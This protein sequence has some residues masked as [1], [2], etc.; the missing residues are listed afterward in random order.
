L[1]AWE[2]FIRA[3]FLYSQHSEEGSR[4]A[5]SL[6]D[7]A[8]ELDTEYGQAYG[9]KAFTLLWRAF[10]SWEDMGS[11]IERATAAATR[12]I[13]C[14]SQDPWAYVARGMVA[15]ATRDNSE[16]TNAF[17]HAIDL[18]PNFAYAHA[19]LGAANAFG[20]RPE[21]AIECTD[22]AVQLSPRDTFSDDF[23]LYYAFAHFQ[24][25]RYIEAASFAE[26]AIQLR[27]EHPNSHIMAASS[28]GLAGDEK[29]AANALAGLSALVAKITASS[30]EQTWPYVLAEDR[31]RL[32]LG[33]RKAGLPE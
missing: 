22:Q 33:L 29:K 17:C 4:T 2:N 24:A 21:A 13:A 20:G 8:I 23:Q 9:L 5:L 27:P 19:L 32:A 10:Q 3:M 1:D 16:A 31:A 7:H 25:A 12:A 11:A 30:V 15:L 6:L 18:S 26:K 14:D 28:Y